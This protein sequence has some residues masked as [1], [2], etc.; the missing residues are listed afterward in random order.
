MAAE[1]VGDNPEAD[2]AEILVVAF[3]RAVAR[4]PI[5]RETENLAELYRRQYDYYGAHPS[6]ATEYLSIG[7]RDDSAD[8]IDP[9]KLAAWGQVCRVILNLQETI[10]RY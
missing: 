5:D 4:E 9:A 8:A 2:F 3:Q 6:E 7:N 1:L 10:T